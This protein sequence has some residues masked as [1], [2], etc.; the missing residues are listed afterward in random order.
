MC[1]YCVESGFIQLSAESIYG[2]QAEPLSL[3]SLMTVLYLQEV[4]NIAEGIEYIKKLDSYQD[5]LENIMCRFC[6]KSIL[7]GFDPELSN[8]II[9]AFSNDAITAFLD[10]MS[11]NANDELWERLGKIDTYTHHAHWNELIDRKE[12][13]VMY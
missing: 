7:Y 4:D 1:G 11:R 8:T 6:E 12:D 9:S 10:K 3:D 5:Y 2:D 13:L